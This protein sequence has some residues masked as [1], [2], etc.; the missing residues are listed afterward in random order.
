MSKFLRDIYDIRVKPEPTPA[1]GPKMRRCAWGDC[2]AAGLYRAPKSR[3]RLHEHQW[4]CL[5]HVRRYNAAWNFFAGMDEAEVESY[6]R[7]NV[8]GHRP[9]WRMGAERFSQAARTAG[10]RMWERPLEDGFGLFEA[11]R[12][13]KDAGADRERPRP[14]IPAAVLRA[15]AALDL[16]EMVS[17]QE[18]KARYKLLVKRY[19]PD[20]NGGD[21]AAEERLREVI[22]AYQQLRA[23][24]FC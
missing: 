11:E 8:T 22:Q 9:T 13:T 12:G 14:R 1:R 7:E 2:N 15:L 20:A 16:D 24:G 19:H 21:R 4:L 5:D 23:G 3:E 18:I 10:A 6:T 17:R